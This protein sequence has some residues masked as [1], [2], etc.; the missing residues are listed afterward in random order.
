MQKAIFKNIKGQQE[1]M[2]VLLKMLLKELKKLKK[3][4]IDEAVNNLQQIQKVIEAVQNQIDFMSKVVSKIANDMSLVQIQ[5]KL[6]EDL[7]KA[8][9][10][11]EASKLSNVDVNLK[12]FDSQRG[13]QCYR[14]SGKAK[15]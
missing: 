11:N 2:K 6:I 15:Q 13:F 9:F 12:K 8:G 3:E 5:L 14:T 4:T 1:H 10:L 7:K